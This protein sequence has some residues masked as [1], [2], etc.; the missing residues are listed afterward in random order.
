MCGRFALYTPASKI[1]EVFEVVEPPELP[2]HYN[3]APTD[4]VLMVVKKG[5]ERRMGFVR[6]GLVPWFSKGPKSGPPLVNARSETVASKP[7]FKRLL[8]EKRCIVPADAFF[9]WKKQGKAKLP[10][11]FRLASHEPMALA[12]L[13]DTWHDEQ[14]NRLVSCTILTTGPNDL[15]KPLHDRMPVVLPRSLW[16][17]WLDVP[18]DHPER[19]VERFVPFPA[20]EME[21]I[22]VSPKVN[23]VRNDGADLIE[24][25]AGQPGA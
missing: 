22:A 24:P 17:D 12:G 19:W 7:A 18:D 2:A 9:E 21:S 5:D 16:A 6:W 23:S 11:L 14:G 8:K 1:A 25:W 15:V 20:G 4:N 10:Y 13:W 3:V